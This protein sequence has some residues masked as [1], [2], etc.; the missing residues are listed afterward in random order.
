MSACSNKYK[1]DCIAAFSC[2]VR[3]NEPVTMELKQMNTKAE[4]VV[5][6]RHKEDV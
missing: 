5:I 3:R 6:E 2:I 4:L 1:C